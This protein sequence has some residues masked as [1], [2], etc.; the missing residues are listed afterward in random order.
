MKR[1]IAAF[2][3]HTVFANILLIAILFAGIL[4]AV[5]LRRE[6]FPEF[7]LDM[8]NITVSYPGADPEEVEEGISRKIEDAI[9]RIEGIKQYTTYSSENRSTTIIE[10]KEN[11]KAQDVI[12]EVRTEVNSIST[13]PPDAEKP[14]IAEMTLRSEV[15]VLGLS[16]PL[17]ERQLKEWGERLKDEI[18]Q[19][20]DVSQVEVFGS[21]NYEIAIENRKSVV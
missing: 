20:P 19:L 13:F 8:I 10:V 3:R 9:E 2:V 16:G 17:S 15:L 1:F 14:S 18:R 12:E 5:K 6:V 7:S 11:Y 21:R 4:A